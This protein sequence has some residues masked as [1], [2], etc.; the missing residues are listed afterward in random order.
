MLYSNHSYFLLLVIIKHEWRL[1][2]LKASSQKSV[3]ISLFEHASRQQPSGILKTA[4]I[5][6]V[7]KRRRKKHYNHHH[8]QTKKQIVL[9]SE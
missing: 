9:I 4:W 6:L 5:G 1:A 2:R 8:Q 3:S 7:K